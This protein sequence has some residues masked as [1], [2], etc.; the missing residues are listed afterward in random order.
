MGRILIVEDDDQ[1]RVLAVG[2]LED[3]GHQTLSASTVEQA[4][5]LLEGGEQVD[6]IFIDIVGYSGRIDAGSRSN[7]TKIRCASAVHHQRVTDGMRAMFVERFGFLAKPYT[8][9]QLLTA[10]EN[11]LP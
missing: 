10:T 9:E 5:A 11:L 4:L 3:G 2:I 7:Q 1:V 8:P 6:L